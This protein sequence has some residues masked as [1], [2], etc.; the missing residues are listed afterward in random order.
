[1]KFSPALD[2]YMKQSLCQESSN[3]NS[4]VCCPDTKSIE[5][6][7]SSYNVQGFSTSEIGRY[8]KVF[9]NQY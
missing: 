1:M 5:S 2:N 6:E 8:N 7:R 9:I 4:N 3:G